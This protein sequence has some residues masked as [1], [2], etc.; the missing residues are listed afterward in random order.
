MAR[1][2]EAA[3]ANCEGVVSQAL[4][5][6]AL[7]IV[8]RAK[9]RRYSASC[10]Q[11]MTTEMAISADG[12]QRYIMKVLNCVHC[13]RISQSEAIKNLYRLL[14]SNIYDEQTEPSSGVEVR[15]MSH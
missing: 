3:V 4:V 10:H 2:S 9:M 1:R 11:V 15:E 8:V 7:A 12:T 5:P 14:S 13:C 6:L